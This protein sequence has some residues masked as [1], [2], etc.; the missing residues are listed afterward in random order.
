MPEL[1]D[2]PEDDQGIDFDH[3]VSDGVYPLIEMSSGQPIT[4]GGEPVY[5]DGDG[6]RVSV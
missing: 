6:N 3:P 2:V 1:T 5:V 4:E